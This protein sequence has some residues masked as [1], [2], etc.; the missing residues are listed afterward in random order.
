VDYVATGPEKGVYM[1]MDMRK[2]PC[3]TSAQNI[4]SLPRD[5]FI[6]V[7]AIC[8]ALFVA[9]VAV[10]VVLL[11]P[12]FRKKFMPSSDFNDKLRKSSRA[13]SEP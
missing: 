2:M 6:I 9:L 1:V 4:G 11:V 5:T 13:A 12:S 8:S 3:D 7:V 10:A